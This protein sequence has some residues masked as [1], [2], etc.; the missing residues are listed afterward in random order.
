MAL[1]DFLLWEPGWE[2]KDSPGQV[3]Y[4][5]PDNSFCVQIEKNGLID[6]A[7]NDWLSK[8][9]LA[10]HKDIS[11]KNRFRRFNSK[12]NLLELINNLDYIF[13]GEILVHLPTYHYWLLSQLQQADESQIE[14]IDFSKEEVTVIN[15]NINSLY[16]SKLIKSPDFHIEHKH[17]LNNIDFWSDAVSYLGLIDDILA[18][19]IPFIGPISTLIQCILLPILCLKDLINSSRPYELHESF[20]AVIFTFVEYAFYQNEEDMVFSDDFIYAPNNDEV[21]INKPWT[22]VYQVANEDKWEIIHE[23]YFQSYETRM[24]Q[25]EI[26]EHIS[27]IKK[28]WVDVIQKTIKSLNSML[29][30]IGGI[31]SSKFKKNLRSEIS[32]GGEQ[33]LIEDKQVYFNKIYL[34]LYQMAR[35]SLKSL[36]KLFFDIVLDERFD[37]YR[38]AYIAMNR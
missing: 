21:D 23:E 17:W 13:E 32:Q 16:F 33:I 2:S 35:N 10:I 8:Y 6:V 38:K 26:N 18:S 31:G 27:Y 22:K 1:S 3:I 11:V 36:D 5:T 30:Y 20:F 9:S 29:P 12:T 37:D 24:S 14:N 4:C 7:Q 34:L 15:Y 19:P 28:L 25:D